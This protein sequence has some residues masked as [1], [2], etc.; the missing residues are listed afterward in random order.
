MRK[1]LLQIQLQLSL[2]VVHSPRKA[3]ILAFVLPGSGQIY[4]HKYWKV[5]IVY[6]G[7][8]TMIYFIVKNSKDYNDG[9]MPT[10]MFLLR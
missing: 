5:P 2:K 3:T 7:F 9:K 4:N 8:G 10:N 1:L 6:A